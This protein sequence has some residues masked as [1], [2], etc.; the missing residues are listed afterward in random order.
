MSQYGGGEEESAGA[1]AFLDP[2]S[3]LNNDGGPSFFDRRHSLKVSGSYEIPKI[4]VTFAGVLK[5]Q[6]GVPYG[7][8]LAASEDI[9]GVPFNQGPITV[10]AETRDTRRSETLKY[11]DFRLSKFF[12]INK[13][14]RLE[15]MAD[16][17]NLFNQNTITAVNANTGAAFGH[18]LDVLG[19]RVFRIGAKY[20]F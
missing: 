9:N 11:F 14:Q 18:A 8:I 10:Y 2:N 4:D 15:V 6:T 12:I 16:F 5:I 7:R 3:A 19:P 13:T 20:N 1:N 17:F